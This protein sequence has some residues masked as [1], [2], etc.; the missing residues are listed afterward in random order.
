MLRRRGFI[1]LAAGL[2]TLMLLFGVRQKGAPGL[3]PARPGEERIVVY[4][5]DNGFHSSLVLGRDQL[6]DSGGAAAGALRSVP[7]APWMQVGW[8]DAK[9]YVE[10]GA[11]LRRGLD[12]LRALFVPNN[13]SIVLFEPVRDRPE[14]I[15]RDGV[16]RLELSP[17]G[18]RALVVRIDRSFRLDGGKVVLAR[19]Q[20]FAPARAFDSVER[21]SLAHL[22][23][24]W[25]AEA[26]RAAGVPNRP[27]LDTLGA[28]LALDLRLSGAAAPL[29]RAARKP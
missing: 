19:R 1:A 7:A 29:D 16:T 17:A 26:L 20:P 27:I 8:G 25:A 23:N 2:L 13:P 21:F 15:W 18:Y 5:V 12:G 11:S 24:H 4:V 6:L 3:Y 14:R 9:F 28:G 22:C 10:H